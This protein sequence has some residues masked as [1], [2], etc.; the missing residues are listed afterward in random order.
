MEA[1]PCQNLYWRAVSHPIS[2]E[3]APRYCAT[4]HKL[5]FWRPGPSL[6]E[7]S[8]VT[9]TSPRNLPVSSGVNWKCSQIYAVRKDLWRLWWQR[10]IKPLILTWLGIRGYKRSGLLDD[11]TIPFLVCNLTLSHSE[12][13]ALNAP[14]QDPVDGL[15]LVELQREAAL[16]KRAGVPA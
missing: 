7:L 9:T 8:M 12:Q 14:W 2:Q 6:K 3:K 4:K 16:H 15:E 1:P 13:P 10:E 11:K 5:N